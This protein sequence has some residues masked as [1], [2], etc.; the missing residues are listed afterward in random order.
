MPAPAPTTPLTT[1][2]YSAPL[3]VWHW[4]NALLV[5]GQLITILFIKVIVKPKALV[6][7]FQAAASQHGGTLTKAQGLGIAHLLSE[8]MWEWHITIGLALAAFWAYWL[9][10][11]L[12]APAERR[13][14]ARLA[15]AARHYRLAPPAASADARHS[16]V[17]KLSYLA[18]Y[19][20]ISVMVLTGLA[21]TW[22]DD[23]AWLHGI[24][25]TTKEI[26]NVTMYLIIAFVT[27]H[28]VGVVWAE[29]TRDHGLISRMVG[30]KADKSS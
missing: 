24:E 19:L 16:L 30:G 26:H 2:D 13:F 25:H 9:V 11:Q 8:R 4:G 21:L 12:T 23:V 7:E 1:H 17:V 3:R 15:A 20:F 18:F 22:A 27:A 14:G 10:M 5:A 29:L 28:I 6:P